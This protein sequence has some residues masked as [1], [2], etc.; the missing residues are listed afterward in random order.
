MLSK[1]LVEYFIYTGKRSDLRMVT[2]LR[3]NCDI[4]ID[5]LSFGMMIIRTDHED[6]NSVPT[7]VCTLNS[8]LLFV[9]T[10]FAVV[11]VQ[12]NFSWL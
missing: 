6:E 3:N 10:V 9:H 7:E 2:C 11:N 5:N 12:Q 1:N 4:F 8:N